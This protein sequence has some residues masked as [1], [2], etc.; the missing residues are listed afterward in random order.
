MAQ[1]KQ[2]QAVQ[3]AQLLIPFYSSYAGNPNIVVHEGSLGIIANPNA[4]GDVIIDFPIDTSD[5]TIQDGYTERLIE[6]VWRVRLTKVEASKG[7]TK[8]STPEWLL[9]DFFCG[10]L[11]LLREV[12]RRFNRLGE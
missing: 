11:R 1:F 10:S 5:L 4:M 12:P 2:G 8:V 3:T 7:L 6:R 9:F